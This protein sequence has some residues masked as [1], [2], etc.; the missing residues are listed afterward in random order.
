[1]LYNKYTLTLAGLVWLCN[2]CGV[3]PCSVVANVPYCNVIVSKFKLQFCY[4]V[5]VQINTLTPLCYGL[6]STIAVH[7]QGWFWH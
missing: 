1:M 7:L 4:Y 3:S 5:H 6:A 2:V